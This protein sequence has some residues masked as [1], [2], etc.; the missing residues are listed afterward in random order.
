MENPE[1]QIGEKLPCENNSIKQSKKK[2][3]PAS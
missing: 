2:P 1:Q 3:V